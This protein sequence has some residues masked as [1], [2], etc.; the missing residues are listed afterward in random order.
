MRL[1]ENFF[2]Q[3]NLFPSGW[4]QI[5]SRIEIYFLPGENFAATVCKFLTNRIIKI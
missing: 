3:R 5:S 1:E 4:R 2:P